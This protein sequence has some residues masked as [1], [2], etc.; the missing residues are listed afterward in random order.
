MTLP[1]DDETQEQLLRTTAYCQEP[2]AASRLF[3]G[4]AAIITPD[5][6]RINILNP[7]GTEIWEFLAETPKTVDE[8]LNV[9]VSRFEGPEDIIKA[10]VIEFIQSLLEAG[11]LKRVNI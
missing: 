10:D 6:H 1:S 9:M 2:R 3:R 11:A 7:I 4:E 8:I 5:N